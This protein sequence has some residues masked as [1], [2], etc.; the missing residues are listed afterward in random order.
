MI[1]VGPPSCAGR[2]ARRGLHQQ[3][4][5]QLGLGIIRG[6]HRPGDTLSRGDDLAASLGVSRTVLREAMRV[7]AD[8]GLVESRPRAGTRVRGHDAW[9]LVDPDVIAWRR[10]AGPDLAFLRHI[11]E[12][13]L[14]IETDAARL[15]AQRATPAD[16]ALIRHLVGLM[17]REFHDVDRYNAVDLEL[18]GAILR[19]TQNPLLAQ[20][21]DTLAAGLVASNEIT[22]HV[23]GGHGYSLPLHLEIVTAIEQGD[24]ATAERLM[25]TL[26][27]HALQDIELVM[28]PRDEGRDAEVVT[29][30]P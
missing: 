7:L 24:G 22:L 9:N 16:L 13:R 25:D 23:P 1:R 28:T 19:A 12:V 26:V 30:R 3:V 17:E 27:R 21:T 15:A 8:K 2:G 20:L 5:H 29:P 18:H 14:V 6:D 10:Q 4:V 11:A